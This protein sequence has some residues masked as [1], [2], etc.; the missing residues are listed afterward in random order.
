MFEKFASRDLG[1]TKIMKGTGLGLPICKAL[2]EEHGG[3]IGLTSSLG[4]GSRFYFTLPE[5]RLSG[6][7]Q[8]ETEAA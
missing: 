2:V 1:H 5:F 8:P 4:A 3:E 7:P 6:T